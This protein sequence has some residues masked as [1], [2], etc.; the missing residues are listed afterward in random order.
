MAD[1]AYLQQRT[2]VLAKLEDVARRSAEGADLDAR[3]V[4]DGLLALGDA[5]RLG[6]L[7]IELVLALL[8][9]VERATVAQAI[10]ALASEL[11][12]SSDPA[13]ARV[14]LRR[15]EAQ[16]IVVGLSRIALARREPLGTYPEY[17]QLATALT[18]LDQQ[19]RT[20]CSLEELESA[21]G[22]RLV[23]HGESSWLEPF[24]RAQDSE[25]EVGEHA[26]APGTDE[27]EAYIS[28]GRLATY[29]EE[30][31]ALD[32]RFRDELLGHIRT[33]LDLKEAVSFLARRF[34]KRNGSPNERAPYP[35]RASGKLAAATALRG[36]EDEVRHDLGPLPSMRA[37][38]QLVQ[39]GRT[40]EL[41]VYSEQ[42]LAFVQLDAARVTAPL[43]EENG[44][45]IWSADVELEESTTEVVIAVRGL[46]GDGFEERID[47]DLA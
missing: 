24:A 2:D 17:E 16:S 4:T 25:L 31:A 45:A 47:I 7:E 18:Q 43:R 22:S 30:F 23:L 6:G 19:L 21:L 38:A 27:L 41:R 40:L 39:R 10:S 28:E 34:L 33:L 32:S 15:D 36:E 46:N 26:A 37:H 5:L 14:A 8:R 35:L 11:S 29:V 1:P 3:L 9:N 42:V 44:V 13:S 12:S 20:S